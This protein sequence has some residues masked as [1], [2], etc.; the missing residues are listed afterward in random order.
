M[1]SA[2]NHASD[3]ARRVVGG[4]KAPATHL[5]RD[6]RDDFRVLASLLLHLAMSPP[7]EFLR[8]LVEE[9]QHLLDQMGRGRAREAR[10]ACEV[11]NEIFDL[12]LTGHR[13][14]SQSGG[15]SCNI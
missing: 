14:G 13:V 1:L 6:P 8:Q 3:L 12:G 5:G 9:P 15:P 7:N 11:A 2:V 10:A 4:A